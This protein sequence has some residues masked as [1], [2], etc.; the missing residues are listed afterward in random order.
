MPI[1]AA[2]NVTISPEAADGQDAHICLGHYFD[3]LNTRFEGGFAYDRS[4]LMDHADFI[5]PRG[6][7]VIAR[8]DGVPIGCGG[9]KQLDEQT[10]EIKRVWLHPASRGLGVGKRIIIALEDMARQSGM[11]V[12]RLDTNRAL[13][14]AKSIYEIMGYIEIAAYNDNPYAH[15]WFEKAL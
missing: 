9:L 6:G 10:G 8:L 2:H 4:G 11:T 5:P 15:H 7:F 13:T 14:E 3:E 12:M 1:S